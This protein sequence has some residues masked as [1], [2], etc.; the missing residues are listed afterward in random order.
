[1][2]ANVPYDAIKKS[3]TFIYRK[4]DGQY[5]PNGT[6]FLV[7]IE[8]ESK[9]DAYVIYLVTAKHVLQDGNE[10]FLPTIAIRLNRRDGSAQYVETQT[11]NIKIY[12]HS[13]ADV[14][15]SLCLLLQSC[16]ISRLYQKI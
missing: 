1:M 9:D 10:N 11:E 8:V 5:R 6:G 16:L 3:V 12:T 13:E 4:E 7:R 14:V 15:C 2:T